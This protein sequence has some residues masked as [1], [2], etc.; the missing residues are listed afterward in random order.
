[1]G[2]RILVW[3]RRRSENLAFIAE[4]IILIGKE[5]KSKIEPQDFFLALEM[6][7]F[8]DSH[9]SDF[10]CPVFLMGGEN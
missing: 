8:L 3:R 1:M 9:S 10:W 5:R 6:G 4:S 2:Y 7:N